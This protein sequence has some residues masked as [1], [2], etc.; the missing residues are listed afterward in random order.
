VGAAPRHN[1][2]YDTPGGG[3]EIPS[4][5]DATRLRTVFGFSHM[6]VGM[7]SAAPKSAISPLR[8]AQAA[9][10]LEVH[11][12]VPRG[13]GGSNDVSNLVTLCARCP[14]FAHEREAAVR[15]GAGIP[16]SPAAEPPG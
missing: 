5:R 13:R 3:L 2:A 9:R 4:K 16:R 14:A 1:R 10:I 8:R 7:G 6:F 15:V 12:V 11:P